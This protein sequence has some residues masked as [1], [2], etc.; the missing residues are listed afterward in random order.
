MKEP[1]VTARAPAADK[2]AKKNQSD[3][4]AKLLDSAFDLFAHQN[5]S[6]VRIK[7]IAKAT[8][9]NSALI[10]YYFGSKEDL[11][12]KVIEAAVEKAFV[13]FDTIT[14]NAASPRQVLFSWIEVHILQFT[15]MQKLAKIS[16]DYAN[17]HEHLTNIDKAIKKF[18][19]KESVVLKNT[20]KEGIAAGEFREVNP[21]DMSM[22]IS[23]F[24][25]G[26][27]FRTVMFPNFKYKHAINCMREFVLEHL[28]PVQA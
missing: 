8:G 14:A 23:T 3:V 19:E 4:A 27:L 25:D 7:D 2:P 26:V 13:Q 22:F 11:F 21:A 9:L 12:L 10:Y 17:T 20:L 5:Y 16:L 18:Y 15:L 1:N 28:E 24:L 6:S